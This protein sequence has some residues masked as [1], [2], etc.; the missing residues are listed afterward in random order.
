MT[1]RIFEDCLSKNIWLVITLLLWTVVV[2]VSAGL[3]YLSFRHNFTDMA[4][5]YAQGTLRLIIDARLWNA[6]HGGVYVLVS[7]ST[8]PNPYLKHP[9]RELFTTGGQTLTMVNPAF[10][11]RQIAEITNRSTGLLVHITSLRPLNPANTPDDWERFALEEFGRGN[12]E[13][14]E[15]I[16]DDQGGVFRYMVPLVTTQACLAC[17]A[18]DGARIG[19]IRGGISVAFSASPHFAML[20]GSLRN[21][22]AGHLLAFFLVGGIIILL[23][24]GLRGQWLT[25]R[26]LLVEQETAIKSRT[27]A[28]VENTQR[29]EEEV[30]IRK[31]AE[32]TLRQTHEVLVVVLDSMPF[33]VYVT[34]MRTHR[35]IYANRFLR[36]RHGEEIIGQPCWRVIQQADG[37][38]FFCLRQENK[39]KEP[40]K[41]HAWEFKNQTNDE[42]YSLQETDIRWHDGRQVRLGTAT[43]ITEQRQTADRLREQMAKY[44]TILSTTTEGF[45]ELD[46]EGRTVAVNE[47]LCAMLGYGRE[48]IMG[49][50]PDAFTDEANGAIFA[51]QLAMRS[52]SMNRAY[53]IC[54]RTRAGE[55]LPCRFHTTSLRDHQGNLSG[56][57][58]FVSDLSEL[59]QMRGSAARYAME[60][61][62]SNRELQDFA[63]IASHDLQE[64]LRKVVAFSDRL[65]AGYAAVLDDRGRDYMERMQRAALRM[66]R[67]IEELLNYSRVTSK[68]LPFLPVNLDELM[69][70][71]HEDLERR[72]HE[73]GGEV[74]WEGLPVIEADRLQMKSL[75]QNLVANALKF[76]RPD[77][78]PRVLVSGNICAD[79]QVEIRVTDNGIGFD[80]KY[81]NRI[82]RPFQRLHGREEYEGTGM[83]LAICR[84]IVDR[85][86]GRITVTSTSGQGTTFTVV[87]PEKHNG[88]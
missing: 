43:E 80:E 38:C 76:H 74:V 45:W 58:A 51:E 66:Q 62:R 49:K 35:I 44:H 28:L 83:G 85:H 48:D 86:R 64:P 65:L 39:G 46:V 69:A 25:N 50:R 60:L 7:E 30:A 56:S 10:M 88:E 11:T 9:R 87:L 54:L 26:C 20:H 36:A 40:E 15:L 57:F 75:L 84:K 70:E 4:R 82:F 37:P 18:K 42:W 29:L 73:T 23:I 32:N 55:E 52:V 63:Y 12:K 77:E 78:P 22:L 24:R 1:K 3:N 41:N 6:N 33:S 53:N 47:A 68:A 21:M 14:L 16:N 34:D 8:K 31:N 59:L 67:L 71:V 17:H 72:I 5:H 19:E 13:K 27:E 79:D 2:T 81:S 61:E